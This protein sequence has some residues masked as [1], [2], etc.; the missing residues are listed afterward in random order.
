MIDQSL[1]AIDE[2]EVS[3]FGRGYGEAICVHL[4]DGE[5][6]L[7]DSCLYPGT[8]TPAS[9]RYL[10]ALGVAVNSQVR[11]VVA[12]HWHDD[13][14]QG[15]GTIVQACDN[16]TIVCSAAI[17]SKEFIAFVMRQEFAKGVLGSGVD[18]LR[19]LLQICAARGRAPIWAKAN[20]PLHPRPPGDVPRVVALA[21]SDDAVDRTLRALIATA[22]Q[23]EVTVPRRY[24]A[25]EGANGASVATWIRN[26]EVALLLGADLETS[27]NTETGWNAVI[28]YALPARRASAVKIPHHG[29]HTGHH[30]EMWSK[31]LDPD[32]LAIITPWI[33]GRKRLPT[34][35]DIARIRSQTNKAYITALPSQVVSA[36]KQDQL[37]RKLHGAQISELRG[38]G[39]VRARRRLDESSWRVELEGDAVAIA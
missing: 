31:L 16:A 36:K 8:K 17:R 5:W 37:V 4:G 34:D 7:V 1:P 18:E 30:D 11:A 28:T 20:L 27:T 6:M 23:A 14:V 29:S 35:A 13:H 3:V 24:S 32:C 38:W 19:T 10:S 33:R 25:P 9:L 26:A 21:P 2:I 39:H 15:I 22:T 12:T